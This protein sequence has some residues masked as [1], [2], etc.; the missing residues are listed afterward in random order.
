VLTTPTGLI[1]LHLF[2][3]PFSHPAPP[4]LDMPGDILKKRKIAVLGSRSVGEHD[5][6]MISDITFTSP[7]PQQASHPS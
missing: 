3:F 1:P 7:S 5:N 6:L 4:F 2:S